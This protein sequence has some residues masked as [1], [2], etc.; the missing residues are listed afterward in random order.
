MLQD[1]QQFFRGEGWLWAE[2]TYV[3]GEKTGPYR[4]FHVNGELAREGELL[5]GV[6]VG[7]ETAYAS[8]EPTT[9]RLR[10][11]CVPPGAWKMQVHYELDDF[12]EVFFDSEGR[13]LLPDGSLH[14]NRPAGVDERARLI[15]ERRVWELGVRKRTGREGLWKWWSAVG[16]LLEVAEFRAGKH[17]GFWEHYRD[18]VLVSCWHYDVG[19]LHGSGWEQVAPSTYLDGRIASHSGYYNQ[20][21]SSGCWCYFDTNGEQLFEVNVGLGVR[22]IGPDDAVFHEPAELSKIRALIDQG[23]YGRAQVLRLRM[24]SQSGACDAD[25]R[26]QVTLSLPQPLVNPAAMS[27]QA[28][29]RWVKG[30]REQEGSIPEVL[31]RL[32]ALLM[33]GG[34]TELLLR[35]MGT[36]LVRHPLAGLELVNVALS[37]DQTAVEAWATKALLLLEIGSVH[38][39]R[40]VQT[41][42]ARLS[43]DGTQPVADLQRVVFP[44]FDYWPTR[45]TLDDQVSSELPDRVEQDVDRMRAVVAKLALRLGHVRSALRARL[46]EYGQ[47]GSPDWLPPD[48]SH[49]LLPGETQLETYSFEA[50]FPADDGK[51]AEVDAVVVDERIVLEELSVTELMRRARVEWT[52]LCW[53]C[54]SVGLDQVALP[55]TVNTPNSFHR[56]ITTAFARHYRLVD[57][58]QTAGLRS[59]AKGIPSFDWQGFPIEGLGSSLLRQARDEYLEMRAVLYF[60][61]DP[62]C[63]SLWQDDLRG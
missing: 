16:Q 9:E 49:L 23:D 1:L 47:A 58:L 43:P 35:E 36:Y 20:G 27:K 57:Q 32:L 52:A 11:C 24:L 48:V 8:T 21:V 13:R 40:L 39:A 46:S 62:T 42:L 30:I 50:V 63:R 15:F 56:A 54:Y 38:E 33:R 37:L 18:G 7:Q 26:Q 44:V 10:P 53:V 31:A 2:Y 41:T 55:L 19:V 6:P 22:Q 51:T 60:A 25:L 3:A 4:R 12:S 28:S 45:A 14:P 61:A 5:R 59:R 17:H 34:S 29:Q